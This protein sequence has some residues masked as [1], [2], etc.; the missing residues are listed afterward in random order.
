MA[1]DANTVVAKIG[2]DDKGFQDGI[3]KVQRSLKLVQ[4]EFAAAST[5]IGVYGKATETLK[6]KQ[7]T[8]NKQMELQKQKVAALS[9]SYE[10]S[11]QKKGEDAKATENL[12]IR[13]NYAQ[14]ELNNMERELGNVNREL[15]VQSSGWTQLGAKFDGIGNKMKTV[16]AGF[17]NTG[18]VLTTT[19]TAPI[20]AAGTGL[21]KLASDFQ[22]ANN[23]VRIG[24]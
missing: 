19:V 12:K 20:V 23:T 18:K 21:V 7:D 9:K 24:T 3:G 8:L 4:S 22:E 11:V 10:E 17:S 2:L 13:L 6:L 5:K 15:Q 1:G 14:A 16:G